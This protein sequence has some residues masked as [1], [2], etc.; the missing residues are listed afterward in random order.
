MSICLLTET[1][2][3]GLGTYPSQLGSIHDGGV[4]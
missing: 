4:G 1:L 2:V 3:Q